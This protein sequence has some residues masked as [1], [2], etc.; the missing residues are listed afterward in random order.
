MFSDSPTTPTRI[1]VLLELVHEMR[2]RK[3]DKD[4]IQ[5]FLQPKGLPGLTPGS[6]QA[7]ETLKAAKELELVD[8]DDEG[9]FRPK[10]KSRHSFLP[11]EVLLDALDSKVLSSTQI[12]PWFARFYAYV[13][14]KDNDLVE[15]GASAGNKWA[16]D[17]NR[18]L[19]GGQPP[20]NPF[21][22]T[23]YSKLRNWLRYAGLGWHDAQD[24]FVPNP[25]ARIKRQLS[26]IF[27]K[28]RKL[29]TDEFMLQLGIFCPELDTGEIFL[30]T[31]K[32]LNL[33]RVCTRAVATA[34]RDLH[35]D[36]IIRLDC[37]ADSRGWSLSR[38]G[39]IRN[40]SEGLLSDDFDFVEK[41]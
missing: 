23:K 13:I 18:D 16:T 19:F 9:S 28:K 12:E 27:G 41:L 38:A 30:D 14:T 22:A 26:N 40:P 37:P 35:D 20:V 3:L 2:G 8:E 5:R 36:K 4:A 32:N 24:N 11:K 10:W 39:V 17:F 15:S 34:L 29:S 31:N 1:E 6:N 25:Y 33:N 21:N 7:N